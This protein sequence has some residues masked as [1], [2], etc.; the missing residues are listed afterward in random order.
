[1]CGERERDGESVS[2]G[3]EKKGIII[4]EEYRSDSRLSGLALVPPRLNPLKSHSCIH[5][6]LFSL[7]CSKTVMT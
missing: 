5:L 1:M 6:F 2:D 4:G 3:G 7:I